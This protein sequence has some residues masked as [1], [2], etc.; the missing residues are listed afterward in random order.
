[1]VAEWTNCMVA[2]FGMLVYLSDAE[3]RSIRAGLFA[4]NV[5]QHVAARDIIL[6]FLRGPN[7]VRERVIGLH[8]GHGYVVQGVAQRRAGAVMCLPPGSDK[9]VTVEDCQIYSREYL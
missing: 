8:N 7:L 9:R 1:M 3:E 4:M 6:S 5:G 2:K